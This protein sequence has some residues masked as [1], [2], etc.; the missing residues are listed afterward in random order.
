[1]SEQP[2]EYGASSNFEKNR[3]S[4]ATESMRNKTIDH[5][6]S[7]VSGSPGA[8]GRA[9]AELVLPRIGTGGTASGHN[10]MKTLDHV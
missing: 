4:T 10:K 1:M 2:Y 6:N 8:N 5:Q 9:R 7:E 3:M